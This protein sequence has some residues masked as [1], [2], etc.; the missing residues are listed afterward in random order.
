[1][2]IVTLVAIIAIS[3]LGTA[4]GRDLF[5][6]NTGGDDSFN[7]LTAQA[8]GD[9]NG[10]TQSINRALHL[11][12]K[13]DRIVIANTGVPYRESIA[14]VGNKHAG[15]GFRP[16]IIEGNGAVLDGSIETPV[17]GWEAFAKDE[18][19]FRPERMSYQRLFLNDRPLEF[20]PPTD[21]GLVPLLEPLQWSLVDGYI[22]FR[23]EPGKM[24][25]EY[26]LTHAR[27]QVGITLRQTQDVV[28]DNLIVQGYYLDGVNAHDLVYN[29]TLSQITA[30]GNGR[31][32]IAVCGASEVE[33]NRCL[34]GDNGAAQ[35]FCEG[36][37]VAVVLDSRLLSNT[38]PPIVSDGG[39]VYVDGVPHEDN[40][41][42]PLLD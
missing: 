18:Y 10:P 30:R 12:R 20:V 26:P 15:D 7:G 24:L 23:V 19:R 34:V 22:H 11:A 42:M 2:R 16:F 25:E 41:A 31:S 21:E 6:S 13:G 9:Y 27:L 32:G 37:A 17:Y 29:T 8:T 40:P 36:P 14:L 3:L 5:V 28:V 1:M 39:E 4:S 38:A 35:L 33:I